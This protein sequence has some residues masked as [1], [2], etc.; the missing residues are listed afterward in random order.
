MNTQ[1]KAQLKHI[2]KELQEIYAGELKATKKHRT[3]GEE[4]YSKH[5]AWCA[6]GIQEAIMLLENK[7]PSEAVAILQ[8]IVTSTPDSDLQPHRPAKTSKPKQAKKSSMCSRGE[9]NH[10]EHL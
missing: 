10:P 4:A 5:A 2:L 3:A 1:K 6:D 9:C 8:T 7:F